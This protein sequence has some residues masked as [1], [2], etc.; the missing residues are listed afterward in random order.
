VNMPIT[1]T[2]VVVYVSA[3][4]NQNFFGISIDQP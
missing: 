3:A 4:A 2:G 1:G